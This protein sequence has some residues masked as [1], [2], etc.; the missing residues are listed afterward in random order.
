MG[1]ARTFVT[2]L[3]DNYHEG[4]HDTLAGPSATACGPHRRLPV[5]PLIADKRCYGEPPGGLRRD[6]RPVSGNGPGGRRWV[7][8]Q[9]WP[10][11]G[12]NLGQR[13]QPRMRQP[14]KEHGRGAA[15]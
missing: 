2:V 14:A 13:G 4:A 15:W 3:P 12:A 5:V 1:C 10:F 6:R 9:G 11:W 8:D 7:G